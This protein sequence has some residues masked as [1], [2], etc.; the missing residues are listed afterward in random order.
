[1]I[2]ENIAKGDGGGVYT[3]KPFAMSGGT[4]SG[5]RALGSTGQGGGVLIK[6]D[7]TMSN[8]TISDNEAAQGGGVYFYSTGKNF[9]MDNDATIKLNKASSTTAGY[10]GGVYV[11]A[12]DFTMEGHS[13]ISEN[14]AEG[15]GGGVHFS[16]PGSFTMDDGTI[17]GNT[18]HTGYGGG[19]YFTS[20]AGN[21]TMNDGTISRNVAEDGGGV[22][23]NDGIFTKINNAGT[24]YGDT[25]NVPR[26]D[27]HENT[28]S[29]G[30][31]HAVFVY[32]N[33]STGDKY[34]NSTANAGD[35]LDST[36][37][38]GWDP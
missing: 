10:G 22:Y 32:V 8:G 15:S 7:F 13:T 30:K 33:G 24:I 3:N 6:D 31:G 35:D 28:A 5:N 21:F 27:I 20:S 12:G 37:N 23:V 16:S 34:R 29:S 18:S 4:I 14:D 38:T 9:I 19:V 26:E 17:S 25:N 2:S 11:S 36:N 1:V